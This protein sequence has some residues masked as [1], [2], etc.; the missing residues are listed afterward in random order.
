L[1]SRRKPILSDIGGNWLPLSSPTATTPDAVKRNIGIKRH[2]GGFDQN[3]EVIYLGQLEAF[4]KEIRRFRNFY[5]A[6]TADLLVRVAIQNFSK[7]Q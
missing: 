1:Y 5:A 6:K 7:M 4:T 2:R 3:R